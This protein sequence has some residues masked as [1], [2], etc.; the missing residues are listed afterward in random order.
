MAGVEW[1]DLDPTAEDAKA[2]VRSAVERASLL[3]M[4]LGALTS[5]ARE[6]G[7]EMRLAW[8]WLVDLANEVD[9]PIGAHLRTALDR[10]LVF[11]VSPGAWGPERQVGF[12]SQYREEFDRVL[13]AGGWEAEWLVTTEWRGGSRQ[14]GGG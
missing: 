9:R 5:L 14:S 10:E 1:L 11:F 6:F 3:V 8:R 4:K 13:G 2:I 7:G 12:E